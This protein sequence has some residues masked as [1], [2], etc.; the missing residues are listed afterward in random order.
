MIHRIFIIG[1][2]GVGSWLAPSIAL[3]EGS[4]NVVLV[5]GDEL[6]MKN[7]NRQLFTFSDIG[8]NKAEALAAK[9]KCQHIPSF[10]SVGLVEHVDTD[11]LLCC[12]DN[13]PAR[14]S[15]LTEC[16]RT[17]CRAILAA[18]E[19]HSSEAYYYQPDWR[20]SNRDPR[21]YYPEI[22]TDRRFDPLLAG[23]GCTGEAQV[24]NR[25]LVSANF[26]AAALAQN[27][28]VLWAMEKPKLDSEILPS[29]PY[30]FRANLTRLEF[31]RVGQIERTVNDNGSNNTDSGADGQP[32]ASGSQ[33]V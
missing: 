17:G 4:R 31:N 11:W 20:G 32:I 24:E 9:Y 3:L 22:V 14:N 12:V 8:K 30:Q 7:L 26:S 1:V 13:N 16:D 19:V 28:Y 6:E 29:L 5:D 15:V 10:Y 2:G 27:L 18:N 25:Q 23:N 33:P 21:V